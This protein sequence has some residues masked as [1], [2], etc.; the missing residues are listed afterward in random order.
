MLDLRLDR[1]E[2]ARSFPVFDGFDDAQLAAVTK[3]L[4]PRTAIPGQE[5]IRRG[6]RGDTCYFI[7]SGAVEVATGFANVRLGRGDVFGEMAL[8]TGLPRQADVTAIAYC[9]LLELSQRDFTSYLGSHPRLREHVEKLTRAR[10]DA[11]A[12]FSRIDPE[13]SEATGIAAE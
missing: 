6:E 1:R 2:L 12:A 13:N 9:S 5:I 11:N 4:R 10:L 8:L 3:F 7:A